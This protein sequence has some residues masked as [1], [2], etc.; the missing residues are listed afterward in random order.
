MGREADSEMPDDPQ[1]TYTSPIANHEPCSKARTAPANALL[2]V[3]LEH[4][5]S[6]LMEWM[7][8]SRWVLATRGAKSR[9]KSRSHHPPCLDLLAVLESEMSHCPA[10]VEATVG[11]VIRRRA[12]G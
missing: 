5:S 6:A 4:N 3:L 11:S 9:A 12:F 10:H 1:Y 7:F 8:C 2:V